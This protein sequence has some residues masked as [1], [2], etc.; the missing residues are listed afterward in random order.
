[1]QS[2][3]GAWIGVVCVVLLLVSV[4]GAGSLTAH[5]APQSASTHKLLIRSTGGG[6]NYTVTVTGTIASGPREQA[7]RT[8]SNQVTGHVGKKDT[9]DAITYTGHI[10]TFN[11]SNPNLKATLD[12][13]FLDA[14][15]LDANHIRLTTP[16]SGGTSQPIRYTIQVS[17]TLVSGEGVED[18]DSPTNT[19]TVS[20]WLLPG[21]S[22]GFYF[23]GEIVASSTNKPST[24]YV[25][26]QQQSLGS[27]SQSPQTLNAT[28][29]TATATPQPSPTTHSQSHTLVI[30]QVNGSVGYTAILSGNITL[31]N[32]ESTD[33]IG[34]ST[35]TG[36]VGGLP[37]NENTSDPKDVIHFTGKLHDFEYNT[38]NGQIRV[39]LDGK[40]V[41]PTSL[42]ATPSP[43]PTTTNPSSPTVTST[44]V[45]PPTA[46]ETG[47]QPTTTASPTPD[48]PTPTAT[49]TPAPGGNSL[50]TRIAMGLGLG[51]AIAG[52]GVF[53]VWRK[54]W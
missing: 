48:T 32:T 41:D 12:G 49:T 40:Q 52:L 38:H 19:T 2:Q 18:R 39:L 22:D 24:V 31:Q 26:G 9:V 11:A 35:V 29:Q 30:E 1:M 27:S 28:T 7:D 14:S 42:V 51:I 53:V 17:K 33:S 44:T 6:A 5:A 45:S 43:P 50:L 46:T 4:S 47:T 10:T 34:K 3:R 8:T 37:W 13:T 54:F 23:R 15:I 25:N 16:S 36:S 20:G 21:D